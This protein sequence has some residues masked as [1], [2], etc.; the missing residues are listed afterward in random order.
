MRRL[1]IDTHG[2]AAAVA[3]ALTLLVA[4]LI[5]ILVYYK[6]SASLTAGTHGAAAL[7]LF[8]NMNAT[9]TT[10][11][12]LMPIVAIVMIAGIILAVVMG[13]GRSNV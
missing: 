8:K 4:M 6:L 13:F 7:D 3:G 9:S 2:F 5:G 11:F 1:R 12:T 10:V